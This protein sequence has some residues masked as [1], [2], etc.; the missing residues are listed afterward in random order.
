M[1]FSLKTLRSIIR[2][3]Y[4]ILVELIDLVELCYNFSISYDLIQIFKFL[5]QIPD[6]GFPTGVKMGEGGGGVESIHGG[7]ASKERG[8]ILLLSLTRKNICNLIG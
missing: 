3:G 2:T 8:N 7:E 5:T 1:C 6:Q 4:P